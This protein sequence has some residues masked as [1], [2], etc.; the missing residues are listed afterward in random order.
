M[1]W[2]QRIIDII[3]RALDLDII[4]KLSSATMMP[5]QVAVGMTGSNNVNQARIMLAENK[6]LVMQREELMKKKARLE[7]AKKALSSFGMAH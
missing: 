7:S 6:D 3:P 4:A 5:L 2:F 1:I